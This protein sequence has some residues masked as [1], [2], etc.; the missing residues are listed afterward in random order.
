MMSE[1]ATMMPTA[2]VGM[3]IQF[4]GFPIEVMTQMTYALA[5]PPPQSS[6]FGFMFAGRYVFG[7]DHVRAKVRN[8]DL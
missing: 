2:A 3:A 4:N 5:S 1:D 8:R 6:G 7:R